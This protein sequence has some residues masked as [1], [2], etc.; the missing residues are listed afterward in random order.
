MSPH[1][2][3]Y[4]I[5]PAQDPTEPSQDLDTNELVGTLRGLGMNVVTDDDLAAW[6]AKEGDN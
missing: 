2:W 3:C 4:H 6:A 1:N 5:S